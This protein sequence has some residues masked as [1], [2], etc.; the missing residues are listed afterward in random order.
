MWTLNISSFTSEETEVP[1]RKRG[2]DKNHFSQHGAGPNRALLSLRLWIPQ[3]MKPRGGPL[4]VVQ[5]L[6]HVWLCDQHTRLPYPSPSPRACSNSCPLSQWCH[7][8]T[9]S[10]VAPFFCLQSFPAWGSFLMSQLFAS[11]GQSIGVLASKSVL[12]MNIKDWFPLGLTGLI[13]L[14]FSGTLHSFGYIFPFL[15]LLLHS[16]LCCL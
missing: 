9:S 2:L 10:S 11:G 14:L 1:S 15:C 5:L 3:T 13:S 16:F 8:T 7:P 4:V 12:P 6:S